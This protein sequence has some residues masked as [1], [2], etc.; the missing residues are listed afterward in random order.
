MLDAPTE[1]GVETT[2]VGRIR[3]GGGAAAGAPRL[4]CG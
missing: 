4:S 1:T 3:M 2:Y